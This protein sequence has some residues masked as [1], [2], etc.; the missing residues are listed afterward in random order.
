MDE[1]T[2]EFF[3]ELLMQRRRDLV[4]GATDTVSEMTDEDDTFPDPNDRATLE[5]DRNFTLRIR[6]RERKLISKIDKALQRI[7]DE[8]FGICEE[9]GEEIGVERLKVRPVTTLCIACK[10][11]QEI[12]E[13]LRQS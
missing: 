7:E 12:Q 6:D 3:K 9:C 13:K 10:Q 11:E 1:Q 5:S 4:E 2:R 8:E